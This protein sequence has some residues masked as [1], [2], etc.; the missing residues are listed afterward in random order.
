MYKGDIYIFFTWISV[1]L[2]CRVLLQMMMPSSPTTVL[3]SWFSPR[4]DRKPCRHR[5][6]GVPQ[7]KWWTPIWIMRGDTEPR[8]TI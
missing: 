4:R 7:D 2:P 6:V 3:I 5:G 1:V 8:V